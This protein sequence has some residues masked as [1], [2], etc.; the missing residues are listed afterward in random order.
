MHLWY[1]YI[2]REMRHL[3]ISRAAII[4]C[5][6]TWLKQISL[7]SGRGC[8]F[9]FCASF[10]LYIYIYIYLT[11]FLISPISSLLIFRERASHF[12]NFAPVILLIPLLLLP[13]FAQAVI[14][15][16]TDYLVSHLF[17]YFLLSFIVFL[18]DCLFLLERP[19][20]RFLEYLRQL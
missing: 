4:K 11:S 7:V 13:F 17:S 3:L 12:E 6:N 16:G 1:I 18:V 2:F 20:L 9:V 19:S 15:L 5:L 14:S 10:I 8:R